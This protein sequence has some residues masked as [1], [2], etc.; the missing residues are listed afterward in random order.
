MNQRLHFDKYNPRLYIAKNGNHPQYSKN[1]HESLAEQFSIVRYSKITPRL[2]TPNPKSR[3]K[4]NTYCD[5]GVYPI[6]KVVL[7]DENN[8]NYSGSIFNFLHIVYTYLYFAKL[9]A[10]K[11]HK[12]RLRTAPEKYQIENPKHSAL[13]GIKPGTSFTRSSLCHRCKNN[14]T[15]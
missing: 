11:G 2:H 14:M 3:R 1:N 13:P 6:V 9:S 10:L 4:I 7:I 12:S 8:D 15:H 5:F